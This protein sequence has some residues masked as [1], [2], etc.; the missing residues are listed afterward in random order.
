MARVKKIQTDEEVVK[1][2]V[3]EDRNTAIDYIN[4]DIVNVKHELQTLN[5]LV[6]DGNGQP[7][8]MQQVAKISTDL[9]HLEL[10]LKEELADIK[11][12]MKDELY[13][14]KESMKTHHEYAVEKNKTSWQFKS[15]VWVALI[16]SLTSVIIHLSK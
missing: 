1:E 14:I 12:S 11:A 9:E 13:D 16:T 5:K 8:L 6:R 7:S 10:D 2:V 15:A 4:R 3:T